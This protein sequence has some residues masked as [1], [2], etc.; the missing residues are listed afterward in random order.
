MSR[1]TAED[2]SAVFDHIFQLNGHPA[3]IEFVADFEK[4]VWKTVRA[5]LPSVTIRG[6]GYHWTQSLFRFIQQ[7]G[8]R[9][10]YRTDQERTCSG[11]MKKFCSYIQ[12][13]WIKSNTWPPV[14]WSVFR[15]DDRTNNDVEG[16]HNR[17]NEGK[18]GAF[19]LFHLID[20]LYYEATLISLQA[21]L[22]ERGENLRRRNKA[23][24]QL[25]DDLVDLWDQYTNDDLPSKLL[26][27]K[28]AT[29]YDNY[30]KAGNHFQIV[31]DSES[32][33]SSDWMYFEF[34]LFPFLFEFW[35]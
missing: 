5:K 35:H 9:R 17:I 4:A 10:A 32:D 6:C 27:E 12:R 2:Y 15:Q 31:D 22:M 19:N 20:Q 33:V 29:L 7:N 3:A 21:K 26:L 14:N 34:P 16:L 8:L 11:K 23:C 30:N 1:R 18:N 13:N 25:Q 24:Q 28:V